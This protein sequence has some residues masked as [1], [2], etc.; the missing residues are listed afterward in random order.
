MRN[1]NFSA[2]NQL[3]G[4]VKNIVK[5]AVNSMVHIEISNGLT[6]TSSVTNESLDEM[7]IADGSDVIALI[8]ASSIILATHK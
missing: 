5:G 1:L 7:A 4:K 6:L 3:A 8:K 2:R